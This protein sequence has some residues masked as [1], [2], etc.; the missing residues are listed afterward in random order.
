M[1]RAKSVHCWATLRFWG[2]T[3]LDFVNLKLRISIF[4]DGA[5]VA[6]KK[7]P[8]RALANPEL[9]AI[10]DKLSCHRD[11]IVPRPVKLFC[12]SSLCLYSLHSEN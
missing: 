2:S 10:D 3:V 7:L 8:R 1:E 6:R 11:S 5:I 9:L 12:K 4:E